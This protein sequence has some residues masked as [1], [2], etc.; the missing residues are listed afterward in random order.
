VEPVIGHLKSDHR[1]ARCFLKG[2]LGDKLN[3]L[4][5]AMG[6]T[7]RKLL[8]ILGT[9]IFSLALLV[10][11]LF[12]FFFSWCSDRQYVCPAPNAKPR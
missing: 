9:G 5:S 7:V 4:G 11:G 3:L 1:L 12:F 8:N 10:F 2:R 6:F